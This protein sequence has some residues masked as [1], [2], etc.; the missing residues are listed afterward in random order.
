MKETIIVPLQTEQH[1]MKSILF[2]F[3]T[4][5]LLAASCRKPE[6][7]PSPA[8]IITGKTWKLVSYTYYGTNITN[9][10]S[11][12]T[13][14]FSGDGTL[15]AVNA[16]QNLTGTWE[17]VSSPPKLKMD[18]LTS[19]QWMRLLNK[20]WTSKLLNPTR[21]EFVDDRVAPQEIIKFDLVR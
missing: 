17:E 4:V 15:K 19:N 9:K 12:C 7:S 14:S 2:L 18:I 10:F 1:S 21:I 20:E 11:N 6:D 8:S 5:F 13:I 16:G 3:V